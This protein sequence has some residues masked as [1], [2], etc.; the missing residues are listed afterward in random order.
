MR[1]GL[2]WLLSALIILVV[3]GVPLAYYRA[4]YTHAKRLRVVEDGKLYRSGQLSGDGLRDA[5]R[6]YNIR[7]IINLQEEAR[8]PLV[9]NRWLGSKRELQSEICQE[10]GVN[11]ITLDGGVLDHPGDDMGSQPPVIEDFLNILDEPANYPILFHC[12][13]GLHRT[14]LLCAVYRME[15][16]GR[17]KAAVVRELRANGFGTFGATEA[18][19]YVKRFILDYSPRHAP[20][21]G[22]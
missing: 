13:A 6:R 3:V 17:S 15:Y 19:E 10:L 1:V 5:I 2:R 18:N 12:K 14:G 16:E 9:R 4:V 7:T 22:R 8:D 21:E 20:N 11:L